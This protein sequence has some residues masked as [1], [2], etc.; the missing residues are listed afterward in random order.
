[1]RF[2]KRFDLKG[3]RGKLLFRFLVLAV[4]PV[5]V[6]LVAMVQVG[7]MRSSLEVKS[8]VQ[9]RILGSFQKLNARIQEYVAQGGDEY[10]MAGLDALYDQIEEALGRTER[11]VD[12]EAK[13]KLKEV[14]DS[15]KR[16][17]EMTKKL[18]GLRIQYG[19]GAEEGK[20]KGEEI[21]QAL[22][23]DPGLYPLFLKAREKGKEFLAFK[24]ESAAQL[25]EQLLNELI[26]RVADPGIRSSLEAYKEVVLTN[27]QRLREMEALVK[28][29]GFITM[30]MERDM[31][32]VLERVA[33]KADR[34][35]ERGFLVI[36]LTV[37]GA[38]A[39]S[40]FISLKTSSG[41]I[42]PIMALL[43]A[44]R[45]VAKGNYGI[46]LKL[47]TGDELQ[48]L[49][50]SMLYMAR[51]LER[52]TEAERARME[53]LKAE[54]EAA[55][56]ARREAE[57]L[58]LE[59]ESRE[60]GLREEIE[61]ISGF[62]KKAAGGDFTGVLQLEGFVQLKGLARELLQMRDRQK[63]VLLQVRE[64]S[65]QVLS[66]AAQVTEAS[67]SL[68]MNAAHQAAAVEETS[69]SMEEISATI[70]ANAQR[71]QGA[72]RFAQEAVEVV[73]QTLGTIR[74]LIGAM[75]EIVSSSEESQKIMKTIDE[76]AFQTNLLSLNA[77][78]E[79]ARAGEAG[80]GFAVVADEIRALAQRSAE[81][82]QQ[83]AQLLADMA[84]KVQR[85]KHVLGELATRFDR[86]TSSARTIGSAMEEIALASAEQS[87]AVSQV[88]MAL[89]QINDAI[90]KVAA[91]A[92]QSAAASE[93]MKAQVQG[94]KEMVSYFKLEEV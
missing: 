41:L 50:E 37:A 49:S 71:A 83:T 78:I 85:G 43:S 67:Q 90:Q 55:E 24:N 10:E 28:D 18:I 39:V 21:D 6:G 61:L 73:G 93:Q 84:M 65:D 74:E 45:E 75:E 20:A 51:E 76:I 44:S 57:R 60:R 79:A 5:V 2:L 86:L 35:T 48:D 36:L 27:N 29:L 31:E 32:E 15:V 62:V 56:A 40:L 22:K 63:E 92:E 33:A 19:V 7:L 30:T 34:S 38:F 52:K 42:G 70:E 8:L 58:R 1:M 16:H 13:S 82:A 14:K 77:A 23:G 4:F 54:K 53:E 12:V 17:K 46:D 72:N 68:A 9:D 66:A 59:A 81:A 26:S 69:S 47:R 64:A 11:R 87:Q 80:A 94:L 3:L 89:S 88:R 91:S 25:Q